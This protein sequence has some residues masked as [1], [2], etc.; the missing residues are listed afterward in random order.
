MAETQT[1]W[2]SE[3]FEFL[4]LFRRIGDTFFGLGLL[5]VAW[6]LLILLLSKLLPPSSPAITFANVLTGAD[7][8]IRLTTLYVYGSLAVFLLWGVTSRFYLYLLLPFLAICRRGIFL[9]SL[10]MYFV[11]L[12]VQLPL[13]GILA[14]LERRNFRRWEQRLEKD[15]P[16]KYENFKKKDEEVRRRVF[17]GMTKTKLRE[18]LLTD[19]IQSI[20]LQIFRFLNSEVWIGFSP[21][22]TYTFDEDIKA[23]KAPLQVLF[24]A[25]GHFNSLYRWHPKLGGIRFFLLSTTPRIENQHTAS[26][27]RRLLGMDAV[28][29]GSYQSINPAIIWLN[30]ETLDTIGKKERKDKADEA[31]NER[32]AFPD[33]IRSTY[34]GTLSLLVQQD[35]FFDA[36][37][38]IVLAVCRVLKSRRR[39]YDATLWQKIRRIGDPLAFGAEERDLLLAWAEQGMRELKAPLSSAVTGDLS[40]L[41]AVRSGIREV[42]NLA[43]KELR[44]FRPGGDVGIEDLQQFY[45][46][47]VAFDPDCPEHYYRLGAAQ[48]LLGEEE[49]AVK[50]LMR[51]QEKDRASIGYGP[52]FIYAVGQ[53]EIELWREESAHVSVANVARAIGLGSAETR[54]LLRDFVYKE[55]ELYK[56]KKLFE[57]SMPI[58]TSEAVLYRLLD[59]VPV[60]RTSGDVAA[61]NT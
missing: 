29:W 15:K 14:R 53:T 28:L 13:N 19:A 24:L 30:V 34:D 54:T 4:R 5:Q 21:L 11:L 6:A 40:A 58:N 50:S 52:D 31:K 25:V 55:S 56:S 33:P 27:L 1:K 26:V 59:K 22:Q 2:A 41:V 37:S 48:C 46:F 49:K 61:F 45:A 38:T 9:I 60:S 3:A 32:R 18:G 36:Y 43:A 23:A 12:I 47:C 57:G 10:I 35:S 42:S 44:D 8:T 7:A 20:F 17:R 51:A 39:S 16:Q